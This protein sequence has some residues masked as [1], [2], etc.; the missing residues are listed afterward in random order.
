[1][2]RA[3]STVT[4]YREAIFRES[5]EAAPNALILVDEQG[6]IVLVN[7]QAEKQF[8][9][10]RHELVGQCVDMLVPQR[11][12]ARHGDYRAGFAR[13][14]RA[15]A[16]GAGRDLYGLRQDGSEF[17]V[18]IGLNP[19]IMGEQTWVLSSI[20]DISARKSAEDMFRLA[21][22]AAPNGMIMVNPEGKIVLV[23]AQTEKLFGY[24]RDELIGREI[25]I[26]VPQRFRGHHPR[27]RAEF[28][29]EPQARGMGAGRDLYGIRKDGSEFPVEIG[30]NPIRKEDGVWVL[31]AIVDITERKVA[32]AEI[33][34]LNQ[35]LERR[36]VE[37]TA[38]MTAAN[39]ELEAFSY[40][41][42]HDLRAPLRQIAG[43]SRILGEEHAAQLDAEGRRYLQKVQSGAERMGVLIDE[44]LNFARVGRQALAPRPVPIGEIVNAAVEELRH[45]CAGRSI[46]WRIETPGTIECDPVFM[47]QVMMNLISNA[48]KYTRPRPRAVIQVHGSVSA[49]ETVVFVRDNGVGFD[50]RYAGKL[51]GIFQRLHPARE[52]EG[53]GVGLATVQRIIHKH[54]GRVWAEAEP[55]QGATF[56]FALPRARE[57]REES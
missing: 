35:D 18:E 22:E 17:P 41:V 50:M 55:D 45:E 52:F 2:D 37:R 20:V 24:T 12:R 53:T 38:Q 32:E 31:S 13:E 6:T 29:R 46:D 9:Y 7:A 42:S 54:G 33:V 4:D 28:V 48:L 36:V 39:A 15:R 51:F 43:F 56:F 10:A 14:P 21:V 27:Q 19:L 57:Q 1:M 8:G 34:R 44:L 16:M 30:L 49:N 23:N 11:F 40:S 3:P 5:F 25:D 26:L 47:K